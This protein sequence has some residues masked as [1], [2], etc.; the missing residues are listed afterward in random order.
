MGVT[1]IYPVITAPYLSLS[2]NPSKNKQK[3]K[4]HQQ[5]RQWR[6]KMSA[7]EVK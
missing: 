5:Q 4:Q 3:T 2:E 7:W 1:I 6:R